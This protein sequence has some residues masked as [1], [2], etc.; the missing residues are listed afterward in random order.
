MTGGRRYVQRF[1]RRAPL[2]GDD[3]HELEAAVVELDVRGVVVLRVD[4]TRPQRTAVLGL[5]EDREKKVKAWNS[6]LKTHLS[7]RKIQDG[8]PCRCSWFSS[9]GLP[10]TPT[11]TR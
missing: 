5:S 11:E 6:R 9:W 7:N 4:L 2:A 10:R 1:D 3:L 8:S